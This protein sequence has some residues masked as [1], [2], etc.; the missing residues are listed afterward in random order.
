MTSTKVTVC[1]VAP[2]SRRP[3]LVEQYRERRASI[4]FVAH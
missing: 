2:L 3:N 4:V 1:H